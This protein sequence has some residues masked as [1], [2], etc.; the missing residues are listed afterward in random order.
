M[1]TLLFALAL[2]F[3]THSFAQ[4]NDNFYGI[5]SVASTTNISGAEGLANAKPVT[6]ERFYA[7]SGDSRHFRIEMDGKSKRFDFDSMEGEFGQKKSMIAYAA[8]KDEVLLFF[9]AE[10]GKPPIF[11]MEFGDG[12]HIRGGPVR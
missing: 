8:G 11:H 7:V 4:K 3:S 6:P 9:R 2:W 1:K 5:C 10:D 12:N